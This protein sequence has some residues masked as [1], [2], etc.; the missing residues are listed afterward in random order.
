MVVARN[1]LK[2]IF[3]EKKEE[4]T[5]GGRDLIVYG[6]AAHYWNLIEKEVSPKTVLSR[7]VEVQ[8]Y[9]RNHHQP[10]AWLSAKGGLKPQ[11]PNDTR[12]NSQD[13]CIDA[14]LKNYQI[15]FEI[16]CEHPD[17]IDKNIKSTVEN[18]GIQMESMHLSQ[19]LK[20]VSAALNK[21]Q[22]DS[23]TLGECVHVWFEL[24]E[25]NVLQSY[26]G[27]IEKR[28]QQ[29][30]TP[31]HLVAYQAHPKYKG[32]KLSSSQEGAEWLSKIN[33]DFLPPLLGFS[34]GD[35]QMYPKSLM[36]PKATETFS[37]SKWWKLVKTKTEKSP[38]LVTS[39]FCTF[40][41]ELSSLPASSASVERIFSTFGHVHTKIRNRLGNDKTE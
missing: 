18:A 24:K 1:K 17:D 36:T 40:M 27:I 26:K 6:C 13:A 2:K 30:V 7:I 39:E 5:E 14:F 34:I 25:A 41:I 15:Y 23:C 9:F 3:E 28:F 20:I 32:K 12:W 22:E 31:A 38:G 35:E 4:K 21:F 19:Q 33:E 10:Q 11:L 16:W 37:P 29:C 8:K